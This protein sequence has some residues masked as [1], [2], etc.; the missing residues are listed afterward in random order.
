[1]G[2]SGSGAD[3]RVDVFVSVVAVL[4]SRLSDVAAF[5][6]PLHGLVASAYTNYEIVLVDNGVTAAQSVVLRGILGELAC[7]RVLRL[8]K[9]YS[10]DTAVFAG[11]EAAIGDHVVVLTPEFD[12]IESVPRLVELTMAGNDIVQGISLVPLGG[13]W[14]DRLGRSA[15]YRYNRRFL[16]VDIP[17][18][19][20]YLTGLTRRAVNSMTNTDRSYRYLRHLMRHVGYQLVEYR[21][22]PLR[23]DSRRR[24]PR[25]GL[26]QAIEMVSSYSTHP[27]RVVT[28]V[29]VVAGLFNLVYAVY[30]VGVNLVRH[31]VAAGWT[32]TSLQQSLMFFL[33]SIILAVQ[34]EYI[35][36]ILNET[37]REPV[38]VVMEEWSSESLIADAERRNVTS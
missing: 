13:S 23:A 18:T 15:F 26:V 14:L 8:S 4:D 2:E 29:G 11:L 38:Y 19:A 17:R 9:R 20:T 28:V 34:S 32:T 12:P 16:G 5:L 6:V 1:M 7:V 37:R 21:Y 22:T 24:T 33:I 27:L 31:D 3:G 25:D 30:V 35:G 10:A 36:R